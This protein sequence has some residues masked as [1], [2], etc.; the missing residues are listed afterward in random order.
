MKALQSLTDLFKAHI[1]DE[2][3]LMVWAE[4]GAVFCTQGAKVDGFEIEY[5]AVVLV[6]DEKLIPDSLFMH[7][8]SWL[9]KYDPERAQKGLGMPTFDADPL[10]KGKFDFKLALDIREE[11]SLEEDAQGQWKQDGE[12][13]RCESDF[14]PR[15]DEVE[16]DLG[17]LLHFVGHLKDLP[18]QP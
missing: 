7:V 18:C 3:N 6:Q 11:Y 9:N 2:K 15:V 1:A 8:V 14:D 13:Y 17:E 16:D 10:D 5:T 12:I 4:N